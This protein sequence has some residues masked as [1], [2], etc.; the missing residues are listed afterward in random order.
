MGQ[1]KSFT[2][3]VIFEQSRKVYLLLISLLYVYFVARYLGPEGYGMV[4]YFI[5][6]TWSIVAI[7]GMEYV[8]TLIKVFM[9]NFKSKR[10]FY[11]V[12]KYQLL[13][14][15]LVGA[16]V[17][18]FGNNI[19]DLLQKEN[20]L[21]L[22]STV[23]L[24]ILVPLYNSLISLCGAF[25][26]FEKSMKSEVLKATLNLVFV[27]VLFLSFGFGAFAVVL[28]QALA[29]II[30]M[31]FLVRYLHKFEYKKDAVTDYV[32]VKK[33]IKESLS[34]SV[35]V[36][37]YDIF[38]L[39]MLGVFVGPVVLGMYYLAKKV[40][41]NFSDNI[42][43]TIH[44]VLIPYSVEKMND[45]KTLAN[46]VSLASKFNLI[47]SAVI[48]IIII[49][50]AKPVL[51]TFLPE[52]IG[53]YDLLY[54]FVLISI[55]GSFK[56]IGIVF[57]SLNE[58]KYLSITTITVSVLGALLLIIT[59]PLY[60]IYGLLYTELIFFTVYAI[61][62]YYFA[63]KIDVA[64]SVVPRK[65]DIRFFAKTIKRL[66]NIRRKDRNGE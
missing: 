13:I 37:L 19:A 27:F 33:F 55:V 8:Q 64:V 60:G 38:Q 28:A 36:K 39:I 1:I 43:T 57:V 47:L 50:F 16:V 44:T 26:S 18:L 9:P 12:L 40:F 21:L 14:V 52:Y 62:N 45:K 32:A 51:I 65:N 49:L 10:F 5:A 58:M 17:F 42:T 46:F 2:K 15:I 54:V 22:K 35:S 23:I 24:L 66:I 11:Q 63:R 59:M 4:T 25:K 3:N 48:G 6:F 41:I 20:S 53:V 7:F 29:M 31:V 30:A 56:I 61:L 34:A